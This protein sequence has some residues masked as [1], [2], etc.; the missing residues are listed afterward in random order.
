MDRVVLPLEEDKGLDSRLSAHFGRAPYFAIVDLDESGGLIR[1]EIVPNKE[2]FEGGRKAKELVL[3]YKPNA[4]I[5]LNIGPGAVESLKGFGVK[6]LRAD[7]T[8]AKD[9][10]SSYKDG[11]LKEFEETCNCPGHG[12]IHRV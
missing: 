3:S 6:V 12:G 4:V 2:G 11:K 10:I 9:A 7:S 8:V 5:V 1:M